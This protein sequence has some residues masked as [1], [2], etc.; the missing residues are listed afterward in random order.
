MWHLIVSVPDYCLSFYFV[1]H[2]RQCFTEHENRN[3]GFI[4]V[5]CHELNISFPRHNHL[6]G[7]IC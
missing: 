1:F 4:S 6:M 2:H 5:S 7:T 3:V